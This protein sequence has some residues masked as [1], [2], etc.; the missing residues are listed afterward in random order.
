MC[1]VSSATPP[2][3]AFLAGTQLDQH[4]LR[5]VV[6]AHRD[7][8]L[9]DAA[10][11][12]HRALPLKIQPGVIPWKEPLRR[13]EHSAHKRDAELP[14]VGVAGEAQVHPGSSVNIKQL[15]AVGKQNLVA[16]LVLANSKL[17]AKCRGEKS[18]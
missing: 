17:I 7:D 9:A 15:R 5:A 11:D 1:T 12:H 4:N 18:I 6:Q 10:A 8:A 2:Q 14:A 3:A 13:C 16:V